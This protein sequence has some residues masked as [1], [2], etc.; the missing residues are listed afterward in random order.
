M[1]QMVVERCGLM[2]INNL[3]LYIESMELYHA[4]INFQ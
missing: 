3:I 4:L 2:Q 1:M